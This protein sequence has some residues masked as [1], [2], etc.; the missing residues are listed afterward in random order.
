MSMPDAYTKLRPAP[1]TPAD[2]LCTCDG[3]QPW[4]LRS[5]LTPNPL[6]CALCNLE[7]DPD[8]LCVSPALVEGLAHWRSFH[9][10][11]YLLW[12]DSREFEAWGRDQLSDPCSPVN[13]RGLALSAELGRVRLTYSGGSKTLELTSS[14]RSMPAPSAALRAWRRVSS[15]SFATT[16]PYWWPT[17]S[18]PNDGL[19]QTKPSIY[20]DFGS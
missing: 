15:A 3:A 18:L 6:A 11:F 7:V 17:E 14:S 19:Q 13:L 12:L 1:P 9:D 20:S 2:E 8:R 4:L 16:A 5:V 10:C